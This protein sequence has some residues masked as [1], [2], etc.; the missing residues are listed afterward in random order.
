MNP[1]AEKCSRGPPAVSAT[2]PPDCCCCRRRE[3][4]LATSWRARSTSLR[5]SSPAPASWPSRECRVRIRGTERASPLACTCA[6]RLCPALHQPSLCAHARPPAANSRRPADGGGDQRSA[7][8]VL[9]R[10]RGG[11]VCGRVDHDAGRGHRAD[12]CV[13][14]QQTGRWQRLCSGKGRRLRDARAGR[15]LGLSCGSTLTACLLASPTCCSPGVG[16][17]GGPPGPAA[18]RLHEGTEAV[19]MQSP[20]FR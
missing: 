20:S 18:V 10:H 8:P 4:R 11:A 1:T 15:W 19:H 2:P 5:R 6:C 16:R 13:C 17:V 7:R 14:A 9:R 12:R 3:T